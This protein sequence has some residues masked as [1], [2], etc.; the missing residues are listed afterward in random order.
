MNADIENLNS[1][2]CIRMGNVG[3][4]KWKQPPP[5][6]I[7]PGLYRRGDKIYGRVWVNGKRTFRCTG[8]NSPSIAERVLQKFQNDETLRQN[9]VEPTVPALEQRRITV[10]NVVDQ[11]IAAGYPDKRLRRKRATTANT[12]R[13]CFVRVR[14]FFGGRLAAGLTLADCD[15]YRQWRIDGG[16]RYKRRGRIWKRKIGNRVID[17]ELQTLSNAMSF[18]VRQGKLRFNPLQQRTHYHCDAD[19]R[20]CR[21]VA[22]TPDQLRI[23]ERSL[24]DEGQTVVADCILFLSYSGVRVNEALPLLWTA[25]GWDEGVIQV[26]RQKRGINPWVPL[27]PEM[28]SLLKDM[29]ARSTSRYLF[30]SPEDPNKSIAYST[31]AHALRSL[32]LSMKLKYVTCHG[33]RS[34]FVTQCRQSG[35]T[36]AE[37]A[38]LIGDK[39]GPAIIARTYGDVRPDHLLNQAKRVRLMA[40][41]NGE[42]EPSLQA[43]N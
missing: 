7:R 13:K 16:F 35:L 26:K 36:D 10:D 39:S 14:A 11:Y 22:P 38:M 5:E 21:E 29:K 25:I 18:A 23:I 31:V 37:I 43:A 28:E 9:G 32:C 42:S 1:Q 27:L 8:T 15:A 17:V 33:L 24:R 6:Q 12:E 4:E 20:H 3:K 40:G 19:T 34:Y 30:P 41:K 2:E